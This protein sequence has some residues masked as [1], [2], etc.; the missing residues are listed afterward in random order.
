MN[1]VVVEIVST[2]ESHK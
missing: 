1:D 2:L